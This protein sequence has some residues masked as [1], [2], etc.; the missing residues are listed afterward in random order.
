MEATEDEVNAL[1]QLNP[2][3][4]NQYR[5]IQYMIWRRWI[6]EASLV[7]AMLIFVLVC[8]HMYLQHTRVHGI[9]RR[10]DAALDTTVTLRKP[11][12]TGDG[13]DLVRVERENILKG[14]T[15]LPQGKAATAIRYKCDPNKVYRK[16]GAIDCT[17]PH[18]D[19][20]WWSN[21]DTNS[22]DSTENGTP[23][24]DPIERQPTATVAECR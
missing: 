22:T 9:L 12:V 21:P 20:Q 2:T 6:M 7:I 24:S 16:G 19:S 1:P 13:F 4:H 15:Q 5:W 14:L 11:A 3:N 18:M 17:E 23:K 10:C 8:G